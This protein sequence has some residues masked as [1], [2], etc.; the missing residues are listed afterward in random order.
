MDELTA[1]F[2]NVNG[3]NLFNIQLTPFSLQE[4]IGES[5]TGFYTVLIEP[6]AALGLLNH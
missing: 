1:Y 6:T 5:S 2:G 3:Q 4:P